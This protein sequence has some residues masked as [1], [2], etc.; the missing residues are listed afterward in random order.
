MCA[1]IVDE[2]L[3][4][5]LQDR[6]D[7]NRRGERDRRAYRFEAPS[8]EP[9]GESGRP[10]AQKCHRNRR[11]KPDAGVVPS[12]GSPVWILDFNSFGGHVH[13]AYIRDRGRRPTG[14]TAGTS[15]FEN[16]EFPGEPD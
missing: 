1:H 9:S 12:M 8:G 10:E 6:D 16:C 14:P 15:Q 3:G 13:L 4:H 7:C 5:I 11:E 2:P